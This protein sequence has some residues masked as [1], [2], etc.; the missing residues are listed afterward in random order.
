ML[1][2]LAKN[3]EAAD[4]Q[5]DVCVIGAG[6]AGVTIA[7][8][9]MRAGHQVCLA[10]SGGMDFEEK[11]QAL[12]KGEN[13]GHEYY[14]LEES[15]LRFFGGTVSIWGG[16]CALLDEIDFAKRAWVPH[17]G[18]PISRDDV[19]PYYRQAQDIFEIGPFEWDDAYRLC[20]IPDQGFSPETL[21]TDLWRFDEATERFAQGR[22][23]DLIDAPNLTI[24]LHANVVNLQASANGAEIEHVEVRTLGGQS[25]RL[26]AKHYVL[27]CGAIENVR[28][29]LASDDVCAGGIGN[30]R[31]Q[32]GRFFMEHPTGRIGKVETDRPFDLW[33]AYQ[34]RFMKSGP[35]LAPVLRLADGLQEAEGAMNSIVT[36]KLQRPPEK[37]VALG[38]KLYGTIKHSLNPDRTGR[39]LDHIYRGLR[40][41]FHRVVRERVEA[42][43]ANTGMTGL[44]MIVRGEQAPNPD[45]RIV[46]SQTRNAL[47]ERQADLNWQLDP[48]DKHT[49]RVF[50][51]V[52]G[53]ELER[54]G[55]GSV[56]PSEWI[57]EAGND[58]PVDPTVGNHPIAGYHHMGGTRMSDDPASGVVD[59]HCKVHG[60]A[61]LHLAGSSVFATAGWANPTFTLVALAL[62]LAE[63][64]DGQLRAR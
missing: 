27:A 5:F 61:N 22:A 14:D 42:A 21:A 46:L 12:Y 62:R 34:K 11:T 32:L 33:A 40:A 64:L 15:R 7:R 29:M 8:E 58:W 30:G 1:V 49:A 59:A 55:R 39:K 37:G 23:R 63:R 41:W 45:S 13:I 26:K 2:D 28:L 20:G 43:M 19:M 51:R 3:P 56:T 25:A 17:S 60:V 4:R 16:R 36:F 18:W 57:S 47:G 52:F 9:L 31:D 38:N 6:A 24:L 48:L 50:A 10:E 53:E 35:P 54:M 44:Y